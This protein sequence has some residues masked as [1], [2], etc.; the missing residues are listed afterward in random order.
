MSCLEKIYRQ[1]LST[2][3]YRQSTEMSA[4]PKIARRTRGSFYIKNA[5]ICPQYHCTQFSVLQRKNMCLGVVPGYSY[6]LFNSLI[7]I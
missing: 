1:V 7:K 4:C 3:M 2:K 5:Q 6:I